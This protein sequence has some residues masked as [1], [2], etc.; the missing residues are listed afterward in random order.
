VLTSMSKSAV[1]AA[2]QLRV[3]SALNPLLWLTGIASPICFVAAYFFRAD[4]FVFRLLIG[5]GV[6]PILTACVG[7]VYFA[8]RKPEKLQS[9][10]YQLRHETLQIIQQ[11]SG[12]LIVDP[13]SLSAIANPALLSGPTDAGGSE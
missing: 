9:E 7:F 2:Q 5:I 12:Q 13:A 4:L 11:K 8:L 10:D 1:S 3:R 6:A